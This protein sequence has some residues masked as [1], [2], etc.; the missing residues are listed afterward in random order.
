M[1][2]FAVN[3]SINHSATLWIGTFLLLS[4]S[5]LTTLMRGFLKFGMLGIDDAVAGLTQLLVY[6]NILSIIYALRHGLGRSI[7]HD[8]NGMAQLEYA[9]VS[10]MKLFLPRLKTDQSRH[11]KRALSSTCCH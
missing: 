1:A 9:E 10:E 3:N 2:R 4:Y 11:F 5:T 6:G 7:A 8:K